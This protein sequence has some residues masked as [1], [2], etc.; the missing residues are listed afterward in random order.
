MADKSISFAAKARSGGA[1]GEVSVT[2][3]GEKLR[4][5]GYSPFHVDGQAVGVL[6][7]FASPVV[8]HLEAHRYKLSKFLFRLGNQ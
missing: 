1:T 5:G 4:F 3:E 7:M 2:D 6:A 8:F